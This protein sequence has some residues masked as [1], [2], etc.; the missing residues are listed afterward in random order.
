MSWRVWCGAGVGA[1]DIDIDID[2]AT[3]WSIGINLII[4]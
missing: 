2:I 1:G 4:A 3:D